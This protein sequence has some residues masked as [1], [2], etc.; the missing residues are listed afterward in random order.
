VLSL[1]LRFH[2]SSPCLIQD[3]C[4]QDHNDQNDFDGQANYSK[5]QVPTQHATRPDEIHHNAYPALIS[6]ELQ[7]TFETLLED[8]SF[9]TPFLRSEEIHHVAPEL[10]L[11]LDSNSQLQRSSEPRNWT[12]LSDHSFPHGF[13]FSNSQHRSKHSSLTQLRDVSTSGSDF[14][15]TTQP[16][17]CSSTG[18]E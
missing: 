15:A 11:S 13:T 7:Q 17:V 5:C 9:A 3:H 10:L 1:Q 12:I 8:R 18:C 2:L 14:T 4:V 6:L 16:M